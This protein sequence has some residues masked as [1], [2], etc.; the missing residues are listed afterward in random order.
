MPGMH[1]IIIGAGAAGLYAA[2]L[3]SGK[4]KYIT[5]LEA[6]DRIGGRIR[7]VKDPRFNLPVETGA[8]FVH[9]DLKLTA[10]LLKQ[11]GLKHHAIAGGIWRSNNGQL[12]KQEDFI[13][14]QEELLEKLKTLEEDMSVRDF[15]QGYFPG[16]KYKDLRS[17]VTKFVEGY[18]AADASRAS[19]FALLQE[20]L[21]EEGEQ[22]RVD[23]GYTQLVNYLHDECK[24]AG[25]TIYLSTVVRSIA[26]SAGQVTVTTNYNRTL[27][28]SKVIIT[29]PIGV[30]QSP[31]GE[32]GHIAIKPLPPVIHECIHALGNTGVIKIILQFKDAFWK[33]AASR[34]TGKEQAIGFIFSDAVVPTW[35]TQLPN[36]NGMITGW[37]A[38]TA[39][40]QHQHKTDEELLKKALQSLAE[41][42][43]TGLPEIESNLLGWH[44]RN[45]I[46][47]PFTRGA[48]GYETVNS[49]NAK[50]ILNTPLSN[51]VYFAGEALHEG[52]ERGTV[53]A[54]LSS[55]EFVSGIINNE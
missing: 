44:V 29:V 28:A 51:T 19:C 1:I 6:R 14:G 13:E 34:Q 38:G 42:F 22:L 12:Q 15:L 11:A 30:L 49:K 4:G 36:D 55:A 23:G 31:A 39:S 43:S 27:T 25:C 18:D 45:W 32:E 46:R 47:E 21:G 24:K 48:Y 52:P 41:I 26:W 53:E 20:V 16:E 3:L 2:K 17:S 35:W 40:L 9:G 5:I 10:K 54:A 37:L 50:R 7:T 8:E 33:K